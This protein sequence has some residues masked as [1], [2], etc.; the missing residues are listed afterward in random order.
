MVT[1]K[2]PLFWL[3]PGLAVTNFAAYFSLVGS[4]PGMVR[5]QKCVCGEGSAN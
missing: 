1:P 3:S 2:V 5:C 4:L